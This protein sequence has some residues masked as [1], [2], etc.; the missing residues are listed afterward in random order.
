MSKGKDLGFNRSAS[1]KSLPNCTEQ[2]ENDRKHSACKLSFLPCKFNCLNTNA[3]FGM[4]RHLTGRRRN[5]MCARPRMLKL[6]WLGLRL[7]Q[8]A[9]GHR[10]DLRSCS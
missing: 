7:L 8:R 1:A 6:Q 5:G 10:T 4:D 3:V 9:V 2:R